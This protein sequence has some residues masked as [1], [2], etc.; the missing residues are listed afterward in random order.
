MSGV[1]KRVLMQR[2]LLL[3]V[4]GLLLVF[5]V[6][7]AVRVSLEQRRAAAAEQ[8]FMEE[9]IRA[10]RYMRGFADGMNATLRH[11]NLVSNQVE[12]APILE[13]MKP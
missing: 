6:I 10:Q 1:V 4:M 2:L 9:A 8:R 12:I 3:L 5:I 7:G 11:V 13:E